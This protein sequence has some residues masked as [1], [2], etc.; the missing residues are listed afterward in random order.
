MPTT[1]ERLR[2]ALGR[3][4]DRDR[5]ILL[6]RGF[7]GL[8][9][10]AHGGSVLAL[11]DAAAG[12]HGSRRLHGHYR[13][14][15]PLA[16]PL[17]LALAE[18]D[19]GTRCVLRDAAG[20]VLVDGGI[21]RV[22]TD[23]AATQDLGLGRSLADPARDGVPLPTSASCFVCGTDNPIGLRA[24]LTFHERL[25]TCRWTP[26][27]RFRTAH[28][29]LPPVALT[30]LLDETAFWLGALATGESGMT[31]ALD[32]TLARTL[33]DDAAVT[34]VGDR[35]AVT[36]RGDARYLDTSVVALGADG[37]VAATAR[38]TFVA[39]RGA[40]RRLANAM[41]A[42]NGREIVRRVFPTY[43]EP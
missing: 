6:D 26:R 14:R 16:T 27:D 29:V 17:R 18:S 20:T 43:V 10:M 40:A 8:P 3:D 24:A 34:V 19:D 4:G 25:V 12:G 42:V 38:I 30:A 28:Q 9:D 32:V 36:P 13:K 22:T 23:A 33:P 11:F 15:V 35:L 2:A 21:S 31:T 39:V 41:L 37:R 1:D 7:Q 5:S